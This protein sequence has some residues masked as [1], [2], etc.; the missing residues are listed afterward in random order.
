MRKNNHQEKKT[1]K[2]LTTTEI[3]DKKRKIG[4][5]D[6]KEERDERGTATTP[7]AAKAANSPRRSQWIQE[8]LDR[9]QKERERI[10]LVIEIFYQCEVEQ[11][12]SK[13]KNLIFQVE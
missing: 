3:E 4:E 12:Y 11:N 7:K 10:A 8:R 1:S 9:Q 13:S 6:H 2:P 5:N